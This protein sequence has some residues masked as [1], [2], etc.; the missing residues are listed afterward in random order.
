MAKVA[1]PRRFSPDP[2]SLSNVAVATT[3]SQIIGVDRRE[4]QV[5]VDLDLEL[6]QLHIQ[7]LAATEVRGTSSERL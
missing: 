3:R 7:K 4:F 2:R 6:G 1:L 5:E